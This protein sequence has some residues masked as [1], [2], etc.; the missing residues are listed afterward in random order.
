M[1]CHAGFWIVGINVVSI[2]GFRFYGQDHDEHLDPN[3]F[4]L[5]LPMS[6]SP[7]RILKTQ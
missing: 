5:S 1:S 7:D 6:P 4:S 3:R 2:V